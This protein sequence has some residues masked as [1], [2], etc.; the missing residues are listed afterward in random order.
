MTKN[1]I[2]KYLRILIGLVLAVFSTIRSYNEMIALNIAPERGVGM[3]HPRGTTCVD[4]L[5]TRFHTK[6][7]TN[8]TGVFLQPCY[9]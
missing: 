8:V 5:S 4:Y 9:N 1:K 2:Y 3:R 7:M 6:N